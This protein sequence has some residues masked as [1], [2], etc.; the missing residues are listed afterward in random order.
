[1]GFWREIWEGRNAS[2]IPK[3][4]GEGYVEHNNGGSNGR[5]N[6]ARI[7]GG[8]RPP[9]FPEMKVVS[10]TVYARGEYVLLLQDREIRDANDPK[11]IQKVNIVEMFRVYDDLLQ[12]H[13]M[14]FPQQKP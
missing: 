7:F 3:Y 6:M 14:F 5:E 12:E 2:A 4:L 8:P 13:W 10:Q 9:G 1:M 11:K